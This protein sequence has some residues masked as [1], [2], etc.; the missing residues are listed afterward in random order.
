MNPIKRNLAW[1]LVSQAATWVVSIAALLIV[2]RMVGD[3]AFGQLSF[4]IVYLSFFDLLANL[5]TNTFLVK[6][7]AR[8]TSM[9]GSYLVN[10]IVMKL[11]LTLILIGVA[12]GLAVAVGMPHQTIVLI[13]AYSIGLLLTVVGGTIGA[14]LTGLQLMTG[15]AKWNMIQGYVGGIASL[16]V[17]ANHGSLVAYAIIF[18]LGFLVSIPPNLRRLWPYIHRNCNLDLRLWLD[19]LKGGFPFFILAALLVVY[20]TIDVP[21]L[22][23]M[24]GSDEVGWYALAYRWVSVPAFF[25]ATV[26]T[27][28][29]PALSAEGV[30]VTESFKRLANRALRLVVFV[31]TPAAIGI[32]LIAEPFL[33]ILYKGEFE[34][35]VP[36]LRI[37]ALHIPVVGMDIILGSVAMAADR[38]RQWV[39][40]SVAAAI[41]NPVLNLAA[42]PQSQHFFHNGAIGAATVTVLTELMLMV[43]AIRLRPHGVLDKPTVNA[44]LRITGASLVMVPVVVALGATPLGVQ[45]VAGGLTYALASLAL[46]TVTIGEV[47]GGIRDLVRRGDATP[48]IVMTE[49]LPFED[50]AAR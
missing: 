30:E 22:Q 17:L 2:P 50:V 38:Q 25:A 4:A 41:F 23:A 48:V 20:G 24:T 31:A 12:L 40:V 49:A 9:V 35:A 14:A 36:L 1:L 39:I 37:L 43:G 21:L 44:M 45:V 19:I 28:F 46:R 15:L 7:I 26:A 32:A 13:A 5:G 42:I 33:A 16:I 3:E 6:A 11:I 47:R 27:A 34:Q 29:F 18:N 8:D 10:A